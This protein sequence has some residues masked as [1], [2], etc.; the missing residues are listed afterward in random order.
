MK[1]WAISV[2][3]TLAFLTALMEPAAAIV[4]VRGYYRSNGTYVAPHYRSDPDGNFNN[5]WSTKGNINPFTGKEGTKVTPPSS[6]SEYSV[7][8][9]VNT[10]PASPSVS[11]PTITVPTNATLNI[12]GTDFNCNAG[13]KR[14]AN[15]CEKIYVPTNGHLVYGEYWECDFG[16]KKDSSGFFCVDN[17]GYCS[18][19]YGA[20]Y[21]DKTGKCFCLAGNLYYEPLNYCISGEQWCKL[22]YPNSTYEASDGQCHWCNNVN[23]HYENGKCLLNQLPSQQITAPQGYHDCPDLYYWVGVMPLVQ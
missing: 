9:N 1:K 21:S 22:K 16:Y 12:L 17:N 14:N 19:K 15:T 5:N 8:Q 10:A 23:Y 20:A 3:L 6:Y 2:I 7:Y 18:G 13:Y 4:S 11:Y